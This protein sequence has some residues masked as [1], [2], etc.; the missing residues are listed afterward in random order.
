MIER[1]KGLRHGQ[2]HISRFFYAIYIVMILLLIILIYLFF[3]IKN[4]L[5]FTTIMEYY[6][7]NN[8]SL[9]VKVRVSNKRIKSWRNL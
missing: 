7:D 8:Y 9:K 6:M 5:S 4:A 1:E 2:P 3:S